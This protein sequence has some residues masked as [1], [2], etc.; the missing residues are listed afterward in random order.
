MGVA[1]AEGYKDVFDTDGIRIDY[2]IDGVKLRPYDPERILMFRIGQDLNTIIKAY[3]RRTTIGH[4]NNWS[5]PFTKGRLCIL[6]IRSNRT[7]KT[8]FPVR[9]NLLNGWLEIQNGRVSLSDAG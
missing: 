1:H 5:V 3:G 8:G 6:I 9:K 7:I 4:I 2:A